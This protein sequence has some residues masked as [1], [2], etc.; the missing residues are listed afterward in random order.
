[1]I[2]RNPMNTVLPVHMLKSFKRAFAYNE[3]IADAYYGIACIYS[4]QGR[5]KLALQFLGKSL[6]WG[7]KDIYRIEND[8]DMKA[9]R[10]D[11]GWK[12]LKLQYP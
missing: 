8:T 3:A 6:Q 4:L 9:I 2:R 12:K 5:K 1:M 7:F 10:D 11:A